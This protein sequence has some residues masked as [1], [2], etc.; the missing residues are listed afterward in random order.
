MRDVICLGE[1]M[2]EL[3]LRD[4]AAGAGSGGTEPGAPG[5]AAIGYAGDTLNVAVYLR[6]AA[7][8]LGVAYATRLGEDPFS[9]AMEGLMLRE[10][11][12]TGLVSRAPDRLPG[13]YAIITDPAGERSFHYWRGEAAARD[14]MTDLEHEDIRARLLYLSGITLAILPPDDRARLLSWLPDL[15]AG[16]TRIAFDSNYRPR[17]WPDAGSAR[18]AMEAAWRACDIALPSADDEAA[19]WGDADE[20]ATL[21]RLRAWG[22]GDGALKRG[23]AGP[24][25]LDGTEGAYPPAER[26]VDTTAAGDSFNGAYLAARLEGASQAA[27]LRAGHDMAAWVVGHAGAI[28]P[29]R[30]GAR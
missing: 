8:V 4:D 2:V 9:D 18:E 17:L 24:L 26:V 13:L 10:G 22:V 6:R 16:G 7:P 30:P 27:A 23:A 19:L 29:R 3:S 1:A 14:V 28:V 21:D 12:D 5:S 15:R 20:A 25:G 11:L